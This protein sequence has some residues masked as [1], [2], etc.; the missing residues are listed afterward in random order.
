[1]REL[2]TSHCGIL[3][4][5]V[6]P[7]LAHLFLPL[8]IAPFREKYPET[9]ID[10]TY[11]TT[12]ELLPFVGDGELDFAIVTLPIPDH[13]LATEELFTEELLLAIPA[14]HEFA[15]RHAVKHADLR[16]EPFIG[17]KDGTYLGEQTRA[18]LGEHEIRPSVVLDTHDTGTV[19]AYVSKGLGLALVPASARLDD[20]PAITYR[21][22]ENPKPTRTLGV[23]WLKGHE[24]TRIAAEFLL[25]LRKVARELSNQH[26]AEPH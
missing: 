7:T 17:I 15:R 21:A 2:H 26:S 18:F 1:M 5:G 6:P 9:Q 8:A 20:F 23:A 16:N 24:H 13:R 14:H 10:V 22:I 3:K 4:I 19:Q 25:Q 12:V 11:K